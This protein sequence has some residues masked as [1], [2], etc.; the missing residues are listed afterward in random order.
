MYIAEF[1]TS[2]DKQD[3]ADIWQG[4]MPKQA[5]QAEIE[6]NIISHDNSLHDFFHGEG[7]P[8]DVRFLMF[9]V[10]RKAEINYF[11]MTSDS[12]DDERFRFD[13]AV[14]K[15][16]PEYSYNWPYD[17]FSLVEMAKVDLEIDYDAKD[18]RRIT[19][20]P[21]S[22]ASQAIRNM[23]NQRAGS[24]GMANRGI[25]RNNGRFNR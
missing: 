3:L 2:L 9:K 8:Q 25:I 15:K 19:I 1:E 10:K 6:E 11:K 21:G 22:N 14:G 12:S 16:T 4:V 17:Y 23:A 7:M 20:Q 18:N 5:M 24:R 13:F